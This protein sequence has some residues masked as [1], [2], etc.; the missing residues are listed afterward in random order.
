MTMKLFE[1]TLVE[2]TV[3]FIIARRN[4][5]NDLWSCGNVIGKLSP[6]AAA[7]IAYDHRSIK[8]YTFISDAI[9]ALE[10]ETGEIVQVSL[11]PMPFSNIPTD[12]VEPRVVGI[13][14]QRRLLRSPFTKDAFHQRYPDLCQASRTLVLE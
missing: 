7:A 2:L 12:T 8:T 3:G 9:A 11:D 14:Q 6:R 10:Q 13:W 4:I 5:H 1:Y